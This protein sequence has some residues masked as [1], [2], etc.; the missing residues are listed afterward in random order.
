LIALIKTSG[1]DPIPFLRF[2]MFNHPG[3]LHPEQPQKER[4]VQKANYE[5][6]IEQRSYPEPGKSSESLS[7][8]PDAAGIRYQPRQAALIA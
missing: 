5:E 4:V 8:A 7:P 3:G 6:D 1:V 2:L